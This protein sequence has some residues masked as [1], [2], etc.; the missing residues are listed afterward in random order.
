MVPLLTQ[1]KKTT[2]LSALPA[3][4]TTTL[5][6]LTVGSPFWKKK[7]QNDVTLLWITVLYGCS[8]TRMHAPNFTGPHH[9]SY[10]T[11]RTYYLPI[12]RKYFPNKPSFH[13]LWELFIHPLT[14]INYVRLKVTF[15]SLIYISSFWRFKTDRKYS[16]NVLIKET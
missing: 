3:F 7:N 1:C 14:G 10:L 5:A 8:T 15:N 2:Y 16:S 11:R 6:I 13:H 9:E 12:Q 4:Q